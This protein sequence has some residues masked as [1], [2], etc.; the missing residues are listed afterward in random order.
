MKTFFLLLIFFGLNGCVGFI[1]DSNS[2]PPKPAGKTYLDTLAMIDTATYNSAGHKEPPCWLS[3][4]YCGCMNHR[5][6]DTLRDP[7]CGRK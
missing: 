2:A 3:P 5:G 7:N 6:A 1:D 4:N